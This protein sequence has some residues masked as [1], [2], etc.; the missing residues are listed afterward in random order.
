VAFLRKYGKQIVFLHLRDQKANKTWT[1]ALGEGTMDFRAIG[2]AL[3]EI[4]FPGPAVIELAHPSGFV[5]T[6][7]LRESLK[8]SRDVVRKTM[9]Y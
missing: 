4:Q 1:E 7:P 5:P 9:G 2:Q 3:R 6:R 8:I